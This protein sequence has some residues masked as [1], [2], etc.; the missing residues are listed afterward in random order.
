[1]TVADLQTVSLDGLT[2]R[3][4]TIRAVDDVTL[5]ARGRAVLR[6]TLAGGRI[7][8]RS[9]FARCVCSAGYFHRDGARD[10]PVRGA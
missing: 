3:F 4:G 5:R 8:S 9:R 10:V 2:K 1:M 7:F 6:H